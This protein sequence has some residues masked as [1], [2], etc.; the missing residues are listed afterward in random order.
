MRRILNFVSYFLVLSLAIAPY[1]ASAQLLTYP[2]YE[3]SDFCQA[4]I[5]HSDDIKFLDT[6]AMIDVNNDGTA[7]MADITCEGTA[8]YCG[9]SIYGTPQGYEEKDLWTHNSRYLSY[10]DHIYV[11]RLFEVGAISHV[12]YTA[13]DN[14]TY[15]ICVYKNQISTSLQPTSPEYTKLCQ[16]VESNKLEQ[17]S[18]SKQDTDTSLTDENVRKIGDSYISG[19]AH[20]DYNN[21]GTEDKLAIL[22]MASGAGRGCDNNTLALLNDEENDILLT[23]D[24]TA[25]MQGTQVKCAPNSVRFL[26]S[27]GGSTEGWVTEFKSDYR[28]R[29][30]REDYIWNVVKYTGNTQQMIC[31]ANITINPILCRAGNNLGADEDWGE[32]NPCPNRDE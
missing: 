29:A 6:P 4:V 14:K 18:P 26:R 17:Y 15:L 22:T 31:E 12:T 16:S 10:R 2:Q 21:D 8:R 5:S 11:A 20:I 23:P 32:H 7:E 24:S 3:I 27:I 13:P 1:V 9:P 19:R 30:L 28:F 25:L